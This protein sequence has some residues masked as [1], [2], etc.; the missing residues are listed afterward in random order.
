MR[1]KTQ[2][3]N[4]RVSPKKKKKFSGF[5]A[6][7]FVGIMTCVI[8]CCYVL[9]DMISTVNGDR[10][11]DLEYYQQNQDQTTIIYAKDSTSIRFKSTVSSTGNQ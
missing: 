8:V 7:F 5:L 1:K 10:I 3:S 6:V 11:I 9:S 2:T 4:K